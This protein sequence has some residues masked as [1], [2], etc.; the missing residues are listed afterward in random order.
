[1]LFD[2]P[3]PAL[4]ASFSVVIPTLLF[5]GAFFI[6]AIPMALRAQMGKPATGR[7]GLVGE[8]GEA[9]TPLTLEGK[10]FVHGELWDAY[11]DPPI[12][13]GERNRVLQVNGLKLKAGR[14]KERS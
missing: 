2:S 11:S 3:L 10:V 9:R 13:E 14:E 5:T 8:I 12:E 1:M 7:E 4:R 6:F